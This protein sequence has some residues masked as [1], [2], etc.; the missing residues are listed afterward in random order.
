MECFLEKG[1]RKTTIGDIAR[2]CEL[3][4]GA[5]YLY[6]KN[7]DELILII[8]TQ[9]SNTFADLLEEQI[10]S[11]QSGFDQLKKGLWLY[12]YTFRE[13]RRYHQLDAEFNHLFAKA[14]P[15]SP[16]LERYYK[17]N[18]RVFNYFK[19][20]LAL[21]IKDGSLSLPSGLGSS[22]GDEAVHMLLNV[23]NSYVE[24]LSLRKDLMEQEQGIALEEELERFLGFLLGSLAS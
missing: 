13:K 18:L 8:M 22:Q 11:G 2:R 24:K 14:Y 7:K 21:G 4:N 3:T 15:D 16:R 5:L 1:F 9:I 10:S 19:K 12:Q 23:I 6:F 20:A 17:A